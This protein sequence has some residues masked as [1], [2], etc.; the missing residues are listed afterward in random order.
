METLTGGRLEDVARVVVG[1]FDLFDDG[2]VGD[3][4]GVGVGQSRRCRG[5]GI[6]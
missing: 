6:V 4:G 3:A 5:R 1:G 2:V